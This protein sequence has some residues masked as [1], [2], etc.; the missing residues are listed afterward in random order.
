[1]EKKASGEPQM[2]GRDHEV[3]DDDDSDGAG[4]DWACKW[5][6]SPLIFQVSTLHFIL[7][8]MDPLQALQAAYSV[9]PDSEEQSELLS[10]LR[11]NLES[12]PAYIPVLCS[13]LIRGIP[14]A[15]DSLLKRWTLD[16][17]YYGIARENLLFEKRTDRA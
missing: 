5:A 2:G 13:S 3:G 12:N 4:V 7:Y 1:M 11:L 10:N 14:G 9:P 16:L 15:H 8:I 6:C 17:V